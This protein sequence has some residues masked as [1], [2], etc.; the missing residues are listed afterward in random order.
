[1]FRHILV[2]SGWML[3][4]DKCHSLILV[5]NKFEKWG[6]GGERQAKV[7]EKIEKS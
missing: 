2:M 7:S 4:M 1:M 6:G 3:L 5:L